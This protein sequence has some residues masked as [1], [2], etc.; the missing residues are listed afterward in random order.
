MRSRR[1]L[2][3][4]VI[5]AGFMGNT[6]TEAYRIQNHHLSGGD[7]GSGCVF[8]PHVL[9]DVDAGRAEANA[10]TWGIP[11]WT[12]ELDQAIAMADVVDICLPNRFHLDVAL[13][14]ARARKIIFCEKP[15]GTDVASAAQICEAAAAAGVPTMVGFCYLGA[16]AI[17]LAHELAGQGRLRRDDD[18]SLEVICRF[19]QDWGKDKGTPQ[20]GDATWRFDGAT[21]GT[22]GVIGDLGQHEISTIEYVLG[23]PI[24][25]VCAVTEIVIAER[26]H[27]EQ[28][29]AL[30]P[31]TAIDRY[32]ALVRFRSGAVGTLGSTRFA[33]GNKAAFRFEIFG[34]RGSVLWDL[35]KHQ[36][37]R[38]CLQGTSSDGGLRGWTETHVSN[39]EHPP[40]CGHPYVPGLTHGY[41]LFFADLFASFGHW[42]TNG[43]EGKPAFATF[44]DAL[45][46]EKVAAAI[47]ESARSKSWVDVAA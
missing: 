7:K 27:A 18:P 41:G 8:Q 11:N 24:V 33:F 45:H 9:C 29:G 19:L 47:L 39:F 23:E 43:Q 36:Y 12:R 34:V 17:R 6:H 37:L 16:P 21:A 4:A 13:A 3:V 10:A 40:K 35:E 32:Q 42:L 38:H 2:K 5:G 22:G 31:V 25:S 20:G 28:A 26:P 1:T 46:A 15:L 14:A 44:A 30:R